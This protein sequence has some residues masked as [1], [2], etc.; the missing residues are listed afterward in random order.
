M[1][2]ANLFCYWIGT[3]AIRQEYVD[4]NK[5][6]ECSA[7][8]K[9]TKKHTP[10]LVHDHFSGLSGLRFGSAASL[11]NTSPRQPAKQ[12]RRLF[13]QTET[14]T[15]SLASLCCGRFC[16]PCDLYQKL[17]LWRHCR[18]R[19]FLLRHRLPGRASRKLPV[20]TSCNLRVCALLRP[21][22]R[23]PFSVWVHDAVRTK[24]CRC[25]RTANCL[26]CRWPLA[27]GQPENIVDAPCTTARSLFYQRQQDQTLEL[28]D[29]LL[30][31]ARPRK[32]P[33]LHSDATR[34]QPWNKL[35]SCAPSQT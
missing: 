3:P 21:Q 6:K 24:L 18:L 29:T 22:L 10:E 14:L 19:L 11:C 34:A 31:S 12:R 5:H 15:P 4:N 25:S 33:W 2:I 32:Q 26:R 20:D 35:L 13:E 16:D 30:C 27:C 8:N 1:P 23:I 7:L 28:T 17:R 9:P